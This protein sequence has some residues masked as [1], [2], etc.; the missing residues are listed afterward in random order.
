MRW[1]SWGALVIIIAGAIA[2]AHVAQLY[3]QTIFTPLELEA[4]EILVVPPGHSFRRIV[5]DMADRGWVKH[6]WLVEFHARGYGVAHRLQAGEYA[7]PTG[8]TIDELLQMLLR[9]EVVRHRLTIPE[10]W[11]AAQMLAAAIEHPALAAPEEGLEWDQIM[12]ALGMPDSHP[13]GWFLPDTYVF[14]RATPVLNILLLSHDAMQRA[15]AEAWDQRAADH[16]V[17]SPYELLIL[18]S[19]IEKETGQAAERGKVAA[20]F[21]NRLRSGMRLQTDPTLIYALEPGATRLTR[22]ELRRDHPYN[23]YTR[24]G[25]PPTPIA[26]PGRAALRAAAQPDDTDALFFVSRND[27]SHHFSRTYAEHRRAVIKY[28]LGGDASRYPGGGA[29]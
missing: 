11:T 18:A 29:R 21:V 23:T 14:N 20:V 25:L 13:E 15:L 9:G 5:L 27:G 12:Q 8:I 26:L 17:A 2:G 1:V 6:P 19:I 10:G 7:L 22:A 24:D 16:P 3:H 4:T 28:Q